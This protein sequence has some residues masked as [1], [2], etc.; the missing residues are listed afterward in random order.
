MG[1]VIRTQSHLLEGC[2]YPPLSSLS[3]TVPSELTSYETIIT[4]FFNAS[5]IVGALQLVER[6][7]FSQS[8]IYKD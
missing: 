4:H 1:G 5:H 8:G 3:K 6:N 2:Y 7:K